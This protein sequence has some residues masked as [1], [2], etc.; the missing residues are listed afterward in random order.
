VAVQLALHMVAVW[1]RQV[2]ELDTNWPWVHPIPGMPWMLPPFR[3]TV[4]PIGSSPC[5]QILL[6]HWRSEHLSN[7][8]LDID[9][10]LGLFQPFSQTFILAP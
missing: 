1:V 8:F 9:D 7:F 6:F 3:L 5:V 10:Q 2:G 4:Q